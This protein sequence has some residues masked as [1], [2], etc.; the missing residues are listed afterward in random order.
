MTKD[1][2][3]LITAR[4]RQLIEAANQTIEFSKAVIEQSKDVTFGIKSA[5]IKTP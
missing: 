5:Y 3:D 4:T 1:D 2:C